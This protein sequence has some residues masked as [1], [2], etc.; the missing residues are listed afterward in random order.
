[1]NYLIS[2]MNYLNYLNL[3]LYPHSFRKLLDWL[4]IFQNNKGKKKHS[5]RTLGEGNNLQFSKTQAREVEGRE[6]SL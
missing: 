3:G 6:D 1:M 2:C 4:E 5:I